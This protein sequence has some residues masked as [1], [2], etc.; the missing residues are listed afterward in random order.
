MLFSASYSEIQTIRSVNHWLEI[1]LA[2]QPVL[3]L[4]PAPARTTQS[5]L[6][7]CGI[8]QHFPETRA[9]HAGWI[10]FFSKKKGI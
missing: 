5:A 6:R 4:V 1:L 7:L 9:T 2:I 3:D 10:S 8:A